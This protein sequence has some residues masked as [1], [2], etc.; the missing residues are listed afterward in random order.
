[1][2]PKFSWDRQNEGHLK[3]HGIARSEAED[4]LA[5][6]HI[7]LEF[8]MEGNELRWVAACATRTGRIL[9]IVFTMRN[10]A[11]RP[12]TGWQADKRTANLYVSQLELE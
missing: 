12:I 4:V 7:L 9:V 6:N 2:A 3:R 11:M 5:G 8:Q 10:Q 1:M